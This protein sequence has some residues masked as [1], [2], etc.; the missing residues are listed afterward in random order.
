MNID[1][2]VEGLMSYAEDD[3]IG[4]WVI[5]SDVR[6]LLKRGLIAGDSPAHGSAVEFKPWP[7]QDPELI[8]DLGLFT[9]LARNSG[10]LVHQRVWMASHSG[11]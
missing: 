10:R 9:A 5:C 3:W 7:L 2:V 8:A 1:D 6:E 11:R 4:L